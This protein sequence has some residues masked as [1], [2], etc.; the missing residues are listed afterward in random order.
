MKICANEKDSEFYIVHDLDNDKMIAACT[1]ADDEKNMYKVIR[2][3]VKKGEINY[4]LDDNGE[5]IT[6]EKKGSIKLID[7]RKKEN[8]DIVKK[9]NPSLLDGLCSNFYDIPVE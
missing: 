2:S 1:E 3:E 4:I 7:V 5:C 6:D 8:Y 9:L